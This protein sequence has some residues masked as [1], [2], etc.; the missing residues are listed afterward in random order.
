MLRWDIIFFVYDSRNI[1]DVR[2]YYEYLNI[3]KYMTY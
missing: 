2:A 3:K 1:V